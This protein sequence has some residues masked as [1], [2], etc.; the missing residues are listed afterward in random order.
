[1]VFVDYKQRKYSSSTH[2][3]G[4]GVEPEVCDA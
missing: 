3:V 1:M 2:R 4:S